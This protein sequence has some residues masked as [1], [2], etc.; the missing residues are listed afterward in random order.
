[1]IPADFIAEWRA[2][3]PWP[4][5]IQ[6]EQDLI[7]TRVLVELYSDPEIARA[8]AFRG[9]TALYKLFIKQPI[10]YSEDIDLVQTTPQ[11]IGPVIDRIR[12]VLD[13]W[14]GNPHWD[15]RKDSFVLEYRTLGGRPRTG[16]AQS[17]NRDQHP[18][19]F[20]SPR[21]GEAASGHGFPMAF[22]DGGSDY[23]CT[24][25]AFG[26]QI[27]GTFPAQEGAGSF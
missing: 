2:L 21:L 17:K 19:A 27:E 12:A 13:H 9:G 14:L 20:L 22:R 6:V 4:K 18:R 16:T 26:H 24:G 3:A 10:R 23:L 1:M 7:L 11:P 25:R 5:D 15:R 8:L